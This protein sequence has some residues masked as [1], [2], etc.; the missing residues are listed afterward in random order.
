M[1]KGYGVFVC[2]EISSANDRLLVRPVLCYVPHFQLLLRRCPSLAAGYPE[3]A[4]RTDVNSSTMWLVAYVGLGSIKK[5][6]GTFIK[7][8]ESEIVDRPNLVLPSDSQPIPDRSVDAMGVVFVVAVAPWEK[9]YDGLI[10]QNPH[11]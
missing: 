7:D 8:D 5:G 11:P 10:I 3:F 9:G 2:L 4:V 6:V 1:P